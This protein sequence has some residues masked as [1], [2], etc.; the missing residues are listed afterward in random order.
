MNWAD[1][2]SGP[3]FGFTVVGLVIGPIAPSELT[4]NGLSVPQ[5]ALHV[6]GEDDLEA[7]VAAVTSPR[8]L[9]V[10]PIHDTSLGAAAVRVH[11]SGR[12][13]LAVSQNPETSSASM[14]SPMNLP[15]GRNLG[16]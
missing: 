4:A 5:T 2:Q 12:S 15:V 9:L 13:V 16:I 8:D 10:L 11:L 3:A 7:F 14:V 6:E 1:V